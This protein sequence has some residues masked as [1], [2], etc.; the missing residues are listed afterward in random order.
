MWALR[1]KSG[2]W[3]RQ[4]T[5]HTTL[6][7]V[8]SGWA[9]ACAPFS[10]AGQTDV[11][12]LRADRL[13]VGDGT[14]I[15][16]PIVVVEGER[17][18]AVGPDGA[19]SVP[20]GARVIDLTGHTLLPGLIDT[21]THINSS[22]HDG[23]DMA[24]LREY[25]AH[26]AIY[27]VVNA[28]K[29]LEAGFTTIRNAGA[30]HYADVALRDLIARDVV[31]GPRL[32]VAAASLGITGGHSDVNGWSPLIDI[33]GTGMV[34]DGAD[35]LRLAVRT[36]VKFGADHIKVVATGGILSAG[37][38][39]SSPQYSDEELRAVVEEATRLGRKVIAH[40]HGAEGLNAAVRAGVASIEHGSLIDEEGIRLMKERGTY[41]VPTLLILDEIVEFGEERGIPD[42]S[43]QKAIEMSDARTIALRRAFQEGVLFAFGTDASGD[44]HGRNA[45]EF[46]V[47]IDQ[48]GA[49]AMQVIVTATS[50]AA[51]LI[52]ISADAGTVEAGKWADIIAV[53]GDPLADITALEC[54]NFVMKAGQVYKA[55]D[56]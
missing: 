21:H 22:D 40:A 35:N 45:Q 33:P 41:L 10:A 44:L 16:S 55:P 36:L 38:A 2:G 51:D 56:S 19:V 49:T 34:V 17:I 32:Y 24:V 15:D 8:V 12:V 14:A 26:G 9:L 18:T 43:I 37:D 6:C 3:R 46:E 27:G 42:Y 5:L 39:V 13:I 31:P 25:G 48:L 30:L 23:G 47:M 29:T 28:K 4:P 1:R 7:V 20:R 52:G 11:T 53:P 50:N 54:V